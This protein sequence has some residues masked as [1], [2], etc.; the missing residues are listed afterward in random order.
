MEETFVVYSKE[1]CKYCD[2]IV[3]IFEA[4]NIPY[5]KLT[6]HEDYSKSEY[7][8]RFGRSTFPRVTLNDKLIGGASETAQYLVDNG[9]V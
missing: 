6:L 1:G 7:F 8:N 3:Q 2:K 5:E 4:K 9:Y